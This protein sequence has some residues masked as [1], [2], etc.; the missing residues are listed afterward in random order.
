MEQ[1]KLNFVD[2]NTPRRL[3]HMP[4]TLSAPPPL[5]LQPEFLSSI[6]GRVASGLCGRRQTAVVMVALVPTTCTTRRN[7]MAAT[8]S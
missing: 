5:R 1:E 6:S 4:P 7:A 3:I 2:Q 8:P